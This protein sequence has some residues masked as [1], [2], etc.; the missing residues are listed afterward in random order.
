MNEREIKAFNTLS[1]FSLVAQPQERTDGGSLFHCFTLDNKT[2]PAAIVSFS[3]DTGLWGVL[4]PYPLQHKLL[5][6]LNG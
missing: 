6:A 2:E 5:K 4:A 3:P 1:G